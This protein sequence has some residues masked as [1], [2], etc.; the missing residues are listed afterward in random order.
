ME[1]VGIADAREEP[2]TLRG[3]APGGPRRKTRRIDGRRTCEAMGCATV[4]S[5]YNPGSLCWQH[6]TPRAFIT[7]GERRRGE[8]RQTA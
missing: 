8:L 6:E 2:V 5:A 7:R 3:T 4:L 1:P